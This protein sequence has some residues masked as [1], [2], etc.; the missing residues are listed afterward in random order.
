MIWLNENEIQPR[1]CAWRGK[2]LLGFS[3]IT[4][5]IKKR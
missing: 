3:I 4:K 1:L 2:V 5:V